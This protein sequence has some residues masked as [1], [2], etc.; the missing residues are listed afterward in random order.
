MIHFF[1]VLFLFS[2]C[3]SATLSAQESPKLQTNTSAF[4]QFV[5]QESLRFTDEN[6]ATLI[7]EHSENSQ[8][9]LFCQEHQMLEPKKMDKGIWARRDM[10]KARSLN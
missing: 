5:A 9:M 1:T 10:F 4:D 6:I 3:I 8:L 2:L 7:E